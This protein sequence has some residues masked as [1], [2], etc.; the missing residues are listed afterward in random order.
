MNISGLQAGLQ[1]L[2][3]S[4]QGA[5]ATNDL[6][7]YLDDSKHGVPTIGSNVPYELSAKESASNSY[8]AN[9]DPKALQS[10]NAYL[11]AFSYDKR[12]RFVSNLGGAFAAQSTLLN[13]KA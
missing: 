7:N 13:L 8:L 12:G 5:R 1:T 4:A 9:T 11:T 3:S 6:E 10:Y 2:Q